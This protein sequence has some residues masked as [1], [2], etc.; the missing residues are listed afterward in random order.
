MGGRAARVHL[1]RGLWA[2]TAA[3]CLCA[4]EV[5]PE[6]AALVRQ[7]ADQ[8]AS[9]AANRRLAEYYLAHHQVQS[10]LP[11]LDKAAR[12]NPADYDNGY[13]LA[14]AR[15]ETRDLDGAA[16]LLQEMLSRQDRGELHN[17]LGDVE[18]ARGNIDAAAK[19][20]ETAARID[21]SE[22]NLFDLGTDLLR[23]QAYRPALTLFR[24]AAAKYPK[25]ARLQVGLGV[26]LYSSADYTEA[27]K[28]LCAAV[29]LDPTDTKALDFLGK[30]YD[31]APELSG[32]VTTRLAHFAELYPN[33]PSANYYYALGLRKRNLTSTLNGSEAQ[34][35]ALL[36]KAVALRPDF[37][38][39][40]FQLG[41]LY[42]DEK[43]TAGAVREFEEAVR[44]RPGWK[45]AHYHLAQL[46]ADEGK[47]E[48]SRKEFQVFRSLQEQSKSP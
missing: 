11:W 31:V 14:L 24:Y 22:K 25:A 43:Q 10:A 28:A 41:L 1:M 42:S 29:D 40:H 47:P 2:I 38:D 27:V 5:S 45:A 19:Q 21:P 3:V 36:R 15:L 46:Y 44:L 30:M 35:E 20:Y 16:K 12:I 9:F 23:H 17:L 32:E 34:V 13:D 37:A 33:N 18:E 6:E 4:A 48:R 26:A 39:A 7:A 8:P